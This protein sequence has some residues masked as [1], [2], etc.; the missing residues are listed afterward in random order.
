ML[1]QINKIIF[2]VCT[3]VVFCL[4]FYSVQSQTYVLEVGKQYEIPFI[5][6]KV[7]GA[8]KIKATLKISNPT[9]FFPEGLSP[10]PLSVVTNEILQRIT[11]STYSI[12]A[13][14]IFDRESDTAF[15]LW[16]TA[17]AG[18]DST[19]TLTLENFE[20]NSVPTTNNVVNI[21]TSSIGTPRPYVRFS[22]F[23][24][25]FPNPITT[26]Q[27]INYAYKID[28]QSDVR[29]YAVTITG[30][31]TLIGDFTNVPLGVH[32]FQFTPGPLWATGNYWVMLET[33]SGSR[34][35]PLHIRN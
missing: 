15:F 6:P 25:G 26:Q 19:T 18:N 14:Y 35:Q 3:L 21:R 27:T 7:L 10:S 17:L 13:E 31:K 33:I 34:F 29:F 22:V 12:E 5:L 24:P 4:N 28:L 1:L 30:E 9:V 2:S 8:I 16:G 11:D 20:V 32:T 23:D